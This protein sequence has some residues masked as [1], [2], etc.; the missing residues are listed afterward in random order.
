MKVKLDLTIPE[1]NHL[2][3]LLASNEED[4]SYTAPKDQYWARA[5]RILKKFQEAYES[6]GF[7][8]RV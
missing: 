3:R 2:L 6:S 7:C 1:A 4:G 5:N 8:R